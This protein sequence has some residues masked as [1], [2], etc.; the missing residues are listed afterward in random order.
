M[1]RGRPSLSNTKQLFCMEH[2]KTQLCCVCWNVWQGGGRVFECGSKVSHWVDSSS[3]SN[4]WCLP[5]CVWSEWNMKVVNICYSIS[6]LHISPCPM[7]HILHDDWLLFT[8][9][10]TCIF[11]G[12]LSPFYHPTPPSSPI[13]PPTVWEGNFVMYALSYPPGLMA[14]P[15]LTRFKAVCCVPRDLNSTEVFL[16]ILPG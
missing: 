8:L 13:A 1:D 14:S 11:M 3:A 15:L 7:N 16:F 12:E 9:L 2:T 5:Q 6:P 4:W 10:P